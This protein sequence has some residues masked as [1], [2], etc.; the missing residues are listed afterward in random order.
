MAI[1]LTDDGIP[2]KDEKLVLERPLKKQKEL[3]LPISLH[4]E[5]PALI[6]S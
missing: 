3:D 1:G 4:E 6:G 5:D 2:I